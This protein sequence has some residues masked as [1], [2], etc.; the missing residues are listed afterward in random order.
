[1]RKKKLKT[2]FLYFSLETV[3]K[4]LFIRTQPYFVVDEQFPEQFIVYFFKFCCVAIQP[5]YNNPIKNIWT[6]GMGIIT[7]KSRRKKK[8]ENPSMMRK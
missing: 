8:T 3:Y 1:M 2:N 7:R 5:K 4:F 6:R